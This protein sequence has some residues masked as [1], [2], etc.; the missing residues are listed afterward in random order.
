MTTN[1]RFERGLSAW[2]HDD[3]TF[4][5]PD[6][7]GEVLAVTQE[8]RQRPAWSSLERWLPVDTTFRPRLFTVPSG[9][10]LI[11][12]AAMASPDIEALDHRSKATS[13]APDISTAETETISIAVRTVP[14]GAASGVASAAT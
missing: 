14:P 12:V 6:H 9:A 8:T 5:V 1:E 2:L 13:A 3:A 4:R 7:L 11:A 10:R